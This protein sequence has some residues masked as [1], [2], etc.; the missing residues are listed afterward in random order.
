MYSTPNLFPSEKN[1]VYKEKM[2]Q[3]GNFSVIL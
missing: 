3:T 2:T 1:V